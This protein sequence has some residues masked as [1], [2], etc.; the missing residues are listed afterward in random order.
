MKNK[1][2][3]A[4]IDTRKNKPPRLLRSSGEEQRPE[5]KRASP[6]TAPYAGVD[7]IFLSRGAESE[8]AAARSSSG[9]FR[10]A[11]CILG[12][13]L[14][15]CFQLPPTRVPFIPLA[16]RSKVKVKVLKKGFPHGSIR[17]YAPHRS[18]PSNNLHRGESIPMPGLILPHAEHL[19][20]GRKRASERY[21][22]R[23]GSC[24]RGRAVLTS[25]RQ[26]RKLLLTGEPG[27]SAVF[28]L[29][30]M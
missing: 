18:S 1:A 7:I 5:N 14:E 19:S 21:P 4:S 16:A 23:A 10:S 3:P 8:E 26:P 17:A 28:R 20:A 6:L 13:S 9:C 25:L 15:F 11:S 24:S 12:T 29:P 22:G 27:R 2:P 30:P